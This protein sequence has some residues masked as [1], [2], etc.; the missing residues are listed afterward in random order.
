MG[1]AIEYVSKWL[2]FIDG[3]TDDFEVKKPVKYEKTA[4][5]DIVTFADGKVYVYYLGD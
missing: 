3:D 2:S 5:H 4:F 1:Q